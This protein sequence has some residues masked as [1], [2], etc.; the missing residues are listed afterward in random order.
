MDLIALSVM[1]ASHLDS[2]RL[3]IR[4]I[5]RTKEIAHVPIL[6]GG[7][8]FSQQK[9]DWRALG[10]DGIADGMRQGVEEAERLLGESANDGEREEAM[11]G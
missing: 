3:M 8:L 1:L 4:E 5:R 7:G 9:I 10:A 11:N 6:I 2:A